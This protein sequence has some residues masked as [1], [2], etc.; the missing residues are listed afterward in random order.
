MR[1]ITKTELKEILRKHLAWRNDESDGECANLI[2][3]NLSEANLRGADLRGANLRGAN[4][5]EAENLDQVIWDMT[6]AFYPIQCPESGSFIGYKKAHRKIIKLEIC[7][8]ALR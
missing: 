3:A 7:E 4:L 1:K 6:T 5:I 2:E 8:D